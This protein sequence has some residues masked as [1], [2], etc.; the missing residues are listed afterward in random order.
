MTR[1]ARPRVATLLSALTVLL[2][3]GMAV[4]QDVTVTVANSQRVVSRAEIEAYVPQLRRA[5]QRKQVFPT[6]ADPSITSTAAAP[7]NEVALEVARDGQTV[8]KARLALPLGQ[9]SLDVVLKGPI[10]SRGDGTPITP[11]GLS[12]GASI[13]FGVQHTI[14]ATTS[15]IPEVDNLA[16]AANISHIEA[17]GAL[18]AAARADPSM[19]STGSVGLRRLGTMGLGETSRE[20]AAASLAA[21]LTSVTSSFFA[22]AGYEASSQSFEYLDAASLAR[23]TERRRGEAVGFSLGYGRVGSFEGIDAKQPLAY[24]GIAFSGGTGATG[25]PKQQVCVPLEGDTGATRCESVALAAPTDTKTRELRVEARQWMRDQKLGLNPLFIRDFE[26]DSSTLEL[27][28][29]A[30]VFKKSAEGMP[31]YEL[32]SSALTAGVRIGWNF[33]GKA[34]GAYFAVFFGSVLGMW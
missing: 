13:R 3:S 6:I 34:E 25:S 23:K 2:T 32:D 30:L 18:L 26:S 11:A 27:N 17:A 7:L 24:V 16:R 15:A 28:V 22:G 12:N 31:A 20:A 1:D 14:W 33:Q 5:L 10:S 19:L 9:S 29:S 21:N 8:G 4:A